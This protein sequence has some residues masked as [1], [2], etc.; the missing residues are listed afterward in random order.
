MTNSEKHKSQL[1]TYAINS[2][3]KI[4]YVDE[5]PNGNKCECIC[6]SCK[7]KLIA[8]NQGKTDRKHHFAHQSGMECDY[9]VES[10]L[11]L[12]AKEKI[13]ETF[14]SSDEF[15]IE[16]EYNSFC[17][18]LETCKYFRQGNCCTYVTKR[19]DLKTYYDSCEQEKPY[20]N[21]NCRSDL[22][23]FSSTNSNLP[24]IYL[25][26][27]VTHASDEAKLH[28]DNRII[29]IVI[30]S[31]KDIYNIIERGL[32]ERSKI[33]FYGFKNSDYKNSRISSDIKFVRYVLYQ[34]G[35]SRCFQDCC[36]CKQLRKSNNSLFEMC[37]H[38]SVN[39]DIYEYAKYI[40]YK[41]YGIKNCIVCKNYVRKYN[42][43]GYICLLYKY[44]GISQYDESFDTSRA[45]TCHR[46][47]LN[48]KEM[49]KEL[50]KGCSCKYTILE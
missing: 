14:L 42:G 50:E 39:L 25:E 16:F 46:F 31:E 17:S 5:V 30:E 45:K 29:E 12:L 18:Y 8:K 32:I 41:K 9:A 36:N 3:G 19:F 33:S 40:G 20:E 37:F 43:D 35:K 26:F 2:E 4:V 7:E 48:K 21:I 27:C 47:D 38:T 44:L 49:E 24:P 34:S 15:W 1:L 22:K 23:I 28:S 10:M 13:C 6:P 11:H